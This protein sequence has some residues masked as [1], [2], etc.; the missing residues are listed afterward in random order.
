MDPP[1]PHGSLPPRFVKQ[2]DDPKLYGL[3]SFSLL[4][5]QELPHTE[6]NPYRSLYIHHTLW[7]FVYIYIH[8]IYI[9]TQ[10]FPAWLQATMALI[11]SAWVLRL[12]C[13]SISALPCKILHILIGGLESLE[14][15]FYDF[16][17]ILGMESSSQVTFTPSFFRGLGKNHQPVITY[18]Q[19]WLNIIN[20]Y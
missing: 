19:P 18:Y 4:T 16:P 2:T 17:I 15:Q 13:A 3:S 9:Y 10:L 20:H 6:A 14:H 8:T 11:A 5:S 1:V 12:H 7:P